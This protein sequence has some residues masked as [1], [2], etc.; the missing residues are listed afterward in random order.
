MQIFFAWFQG[1]IRS[2]NR[3]SLQFNKKDLFES[4][5]EIRQ[6]ILFR[7]KKYRCSNQ[8]TVLPNDAPEPHLH[9]FNV[10]QYTADYSER[11]C[12]IKK[13]SFNVVIS[14]NT[15]KLIVKLE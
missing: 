14:N 2:I 8:I 1:S 4:F 9:N 15:I 10:H 5:V 11:R 13:M 12:C 7:K 3:V 6:R